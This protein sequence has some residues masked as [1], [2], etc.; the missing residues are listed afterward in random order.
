[1]TA[2]KMMMAETKATVKKSDSVQHT[3]FLILAAAGS[4]TR[5]GIG[6]KKEY[7]TLNSGTVLSESAAIFL[8]SAHLEAIVVTIPFGEELHAHDAFFA[9]KDMTSLLG[10]TKLFLIQGGDTRQQSVFNALK[11]IKAEFCNAADSIVLIHDAARPFVTSKIIKDTIEATELYGAA[12]PAVTPTDTQKEI[13]SDHT[14]LRH[15]VRSELGAVQTPQAFLFG[16]LLACHEQAALLAKEFT[17]DTEIWDAFPSLTQNKKVHVVSGDSCNKKITYITD[18]PASSKLLFSKENN[19]MNTIHS[20][21]GTDLHRLVAG[22][23]LMLGG[24]EIPFNK[25]E[26]GHSDGDVLLHA[27]TD[28]LLGAS[29]L[30]DIGSYFPPED[31][32]W[33]DADSALLLRQVWSDI[34][35]AGWTL[36]NLDCVVELEQPKFIPYRTQVISSIAHILA[37]NEDQV[38]VKAKTNEKLEAVGQSEAVKAYCVCLL[39]R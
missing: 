7:L 11:K 14:I 1:M 27:I 30:G 15:L 32:K 25:G 39:S 6:G 8:K 36:C 18:I 19:T 21:I 31:P 37:V 33:K 10:S 5:M 34:T 24:I 2:K 20:G 28:A 29:G 38:F 9:D 3:C 22:R 17:D 26:L 23:K 13:A 16:P 35:K 12:V 4:S